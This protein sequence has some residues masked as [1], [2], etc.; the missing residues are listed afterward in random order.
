[1]HI[2][3]WNFNYYWWIWKSWDVLTVKPEKLIL[4]NYHNTKQEKETD[5]PK[6]SVCFILIP[7]HFRATE[8]L[9]IVI[10]L[11]DG[12]QFCFSL[13]SKKAKLQRENHAFLY[14]G[15]NWRQKYPGWQRTEPN[16][17]WTVR[18]C[19]D[20]APCLNSLKYPRETLFKSPL[21]T[22]LLWAKKFHSPS[23][24][25]ICFAAVSS[26]NNNNP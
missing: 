25:N 4:Y 10:T 20:L 7:C 18:D 26:K 6:S 19:C 17:F 9:I 16:M 3:I 1:M 11:L 8:F 13:H 24:M 5:S 22:N 2:L 21:Q 23:G 12:E 14:F 15:Q